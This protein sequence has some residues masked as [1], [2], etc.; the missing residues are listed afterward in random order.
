MEFDYL[1]KRAKH[2][3]CEKEEQFSLESTKIHTQ[4]TQ[5]LT[6]HSPLSISLSAYTTTT[7]TQEES[8]E[9]PPLHTRGDNYNKT[10]TLLL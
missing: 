10:T 9:N 6:P 7:T 8:E 1:A 5:L 3:K 2:V 4:R